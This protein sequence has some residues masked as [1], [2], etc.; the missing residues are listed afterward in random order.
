MVSSYFWSIDFWGGLS[1]YN[2]HR[3]R[4]NI[5]FIGLIVASGMIATLAGPATAILMIPRIQDWEAGGMIFW[6]NGRCLTMQSDRDTFKPDVLTGSDAQLWPTNLDAEYSSSYPCSSSGRN[7]THDYSCPSAGFETLNSFFSTWWNHN[8]A[9]HTYM[10]SDF[11]I[12][13]LFYIL[14]NT[15]GDKDTWMYIAHAASSNMQ[16]AAA[17]YHKNAMTWLKANMLDQWP[18]PGRL[19][20]AQSK[21]FELETKIPAVRV[22]CNASATIPVA[23]GYDGNPFNVSFPELQQFSRFRSN[24]TYTVVD[25]SDTISQYL[26]Q[27]G[28]MARN[29]SSYSMT[30]LAPSLI[31]VPVPNVPAGNASS[32]GFVLL[33]G[34]DNDTL[35]PIGCTVDARW[36]K[37]LS[38][39]KNAF[40]GQEIMT[41]EYVDDRSRNPIRTELESDDY[42]ATV[43]GTFGPRY[44]DTWKHIDISMD[45][46]QLLSPSWSHYLNSTQESADSTKASNMT[47]DMTLLEKLLE[48]SG[49]ATANET[50]YSTIMGRSSLE[51]VIAALFV[52]GLSRVGVQFQVDTQQLL[53]WR[54]INEDPGAIHKTLVRNGPPIESF[55]M[56]EALRR[57]PSTRMVVRAKFSGYAMVLSNWF[58]YLSA[59]VLLLHAVMAL[60][61]TGLTLWQKQT[62]EAWDT[63]TELV[64]LS[65]QSQLAR[66]EVLANTCAGIRTFRTM[67]AIA[68]VETRENRKLGE[69]AVQL[70]IRRSW[71]KRDPDSWPIPGREY[72]VM[73]YQAQRV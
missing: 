20:Q 42:I 57:S 25:L 10:L 44:P 37:G 64:V 7:L 50:S 45:W 15:S 33:K 54:E 1:A 38:N 29:G 61:Q 55:P 39:V 41:H 49:I 4:N 70:R 73:Q 23:T 60:L 30:T 31:A 48:T 40:D 69:E 63:V 21:S 3:R 58:D 52:D 22:A 11:H 27:R 2:G 18:Y 43:D 24:E 72:G 5:W 71:A 6:L 59:G 35:L 8:D 19:D 56:P 17:D 26:L 62:G 16:D 51:V 14:S 66:N 47:Q 13:K 9:V 68:Q 34:L 36:T 65:Q 12:R 28:M 46:Y 32:I 53:G 67:S